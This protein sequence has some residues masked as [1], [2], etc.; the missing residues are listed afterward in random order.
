VVQAGWE[1]KWDL[2]SKLTRAQRA[3]GEAQAVAS[4]PTKCGAL[5]SNPDTATKKK[6]RKAS[7]QI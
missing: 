4:L 6:R 3:R 7:K 1:K 5:N 2:I